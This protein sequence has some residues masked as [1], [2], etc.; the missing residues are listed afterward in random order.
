MKVKIKKKSILCYPFF[1]KKLRKTRRKKKHMF[2]TSSIQLQIHQDVLDNINETE[3]FL[4]LQNEAGNLDPFLF[5]SYMNEI[6]AY[7]P[8]SP[9]QV[10]AEPIHMSA[11]P[12]D[13]RWLDFSL[14]QTEKNFFLSFNDPAK[15]ELIQMRL[16]PFEE[17]VHLN[18]YEIPNLETTFY[19]TYP[20][21]KLLGKEG[22]KPIKER[23]WMDHQW[24][25]FNNWFFSKS[26]KK[27]IW[28]GI[29]SG[30]T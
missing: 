26:D 24:G 21:M 13:I 8:P 28:D 25:D 14:K 27:N 20:R 22:S 2:S 29:G 18:D 12:L 19:N 11:H 10:S 4:L 3:Q 30:S 9:I 15:K 23:A 17:V 1:G 7:G 5:K 6:K 16:S